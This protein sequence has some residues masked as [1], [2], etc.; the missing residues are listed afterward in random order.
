MKFDSARIHF[1]GDVSLPFPLSLIKLLNMLLDTLCSSSC[2]LLSMDTVN[3]NP[4][5]GGG[6]VAHSKL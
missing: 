2:L 3:T 5:G 6:G 1:L 4:G